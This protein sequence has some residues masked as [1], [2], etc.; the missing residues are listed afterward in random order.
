[1][2]ITSMTFFHM[3]AIGISFIDMANIFLLFAICFYGE[4]KLPPSQLCSAAANIGA[5]EAKI[6][7]KK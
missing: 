3:L 6:N 5:Q 4:R 1:M 7:E 2:K